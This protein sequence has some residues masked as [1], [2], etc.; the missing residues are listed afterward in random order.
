M[1]FFSK[2][3]KAAIDTAMLPVEVVKDFAT[4]GNVLDGEPYTLDRL[5]Q[6]GRDIEEAKKALDE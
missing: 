1:G 3:A 5:K 6:I 4:F 2:L